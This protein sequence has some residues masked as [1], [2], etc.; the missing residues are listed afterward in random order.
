MLE[1]AACKRV[2]T[3]VLFVGHD[4]N[5]AVF[6]ADGETRRELRRLLAGVVKPVDRRNLFLTRSRT[7]V[8]DF[9]LER[10]Q[11]ATFVSNCRV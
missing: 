10:Y 1:H 9:G 2:L 3:F 6:K 4:L 7:K 8:G 5:V 11:S